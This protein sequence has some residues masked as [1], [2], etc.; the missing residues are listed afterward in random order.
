MASGT[1]IYLD[2]MGAVTCQAGPCPPP[3]HLHV[4]GNRAEHFCLSRICQHLPCSLWACSQDGRGY[5]ASM[6]TFCG[7]GL[8]RQ[9]ISLSEDRQWLKWGGRVAEMEKVGSPKTY[10]KMTSASWRSL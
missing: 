1:K 5:V 3:S 10:I 9:G 8:E 7:W 4:L 6:H 2:H